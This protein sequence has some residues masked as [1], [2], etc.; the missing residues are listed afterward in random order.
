VE[1]ASAEATR[2]MERAAWYFGDFM[3][4]LLSDVLNSSSTAL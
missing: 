2:A 4:L 3:E 1:Q